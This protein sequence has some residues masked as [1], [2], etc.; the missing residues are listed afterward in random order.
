MNLAVASGLL[1]ACRAMQRG[2][3]GIDSSGPASP[4]KVAAKRR[5][6]ELVGMIARPGQVALEVGAETNY[7]AM[8]AEL[9]ITVIPQNLPADMHA[10]DAEAE[11]DG[12]IAMH[13]LEHSPFPLYVLAMLHRAVRPGGWLYVAVPHVNARWA[14]DAAHFSVLHP[15]NWARLL[16]VAGWRVLERE[17]GKLG[18]KPEKVEERFLCSRP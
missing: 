8:F 15:D 5:A 11:Y 13:V 14:R 7:A 18:P 4:E 3:L 16:D 6:A 17:S 9:G 1:E 10:L 2:H 12:A